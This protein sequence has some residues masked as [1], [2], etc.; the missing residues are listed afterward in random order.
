MIN[1]YD[2]S[3]GAE[4]FNKIFEQAYAKFTE[5][6]ENGEIVN[7]DVGWFNCNVVEHPELKI[8]HVHY[9]NQVITPD[10]FTMKKVLHFHPL[11]DE[12][13]LSGDIDSV[14]FKFVDAVWTFTGNWVPEAQCEEILHP[15]WE[16][17]KTLWDVIYFG[18]EESLLA[19]IEVEGHEEETSR[20]Q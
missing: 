17:A 7:R 5:L 20:L 16:G 4:A 18:S 12:H 6:E 11:K 19:P 15:E 9:P 2:S 13:W 14:V 10:T 3:E 8:E 1:F